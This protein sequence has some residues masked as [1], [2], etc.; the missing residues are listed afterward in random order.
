MAESEGRK[1]LGYGLSYDERI[2]LAQLV[3][4]PGWKILVRLMAEACRNATEEVIKLKPTTERYAEV[5]TGLQ[6]T[7]HAMNKFSAEVLDSVKVH[8]RAAVQ[9]AQQRENPSLVAAD[10]KNRFQMPMPKSP[11]EGTKSNQ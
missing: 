7:A 10:P 5:L 9:E 2:G 8:Q 1:L 4:Q 11:V 6:T 3:N